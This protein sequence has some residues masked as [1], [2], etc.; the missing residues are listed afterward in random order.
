MDFGIARELSHDTGTTST[1]LT[2]DGESL[3]RPGYIAPEQFEGKEATPATD[4]YA[5]DISLR[6]VTGVAP[7]RKSHKPKALS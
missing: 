7:S 4:V 1:A 5:L 2:T 3:I 6:L